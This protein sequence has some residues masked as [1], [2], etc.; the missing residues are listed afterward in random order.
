[1][2]DFENCGAILGVSGVRYGDNWMEL[3]VG[4]HS[5]NVPVRGIPVPNIFLVDRVIVRD[6]N[7]FDVWNVDSSCDWDITSKTASELI[8]VIINF[9]MSV[10]KWDTDHFDVEVYI[11]PN[12][13]LQNKER[14]AEFIQGVERPWIACDFN[15]VV[16]NEKTY[17]RFVNFHVD[18]KKCKGGVI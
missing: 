12:S 17:V 1:M 16:I 3:K 7:Y 2:V 15:N 18:C 6:L 8:T 10:R 5:I 13:S 9:I 11:W 14:L 4:K